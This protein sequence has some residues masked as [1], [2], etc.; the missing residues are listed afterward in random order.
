MNW[1]DGILL[2]NKENKKI[3][4]QKEWEIWRSVYPDMDKD[5]YIS[6]EDFRIKNSEV[7]QQINKPILTQ[8]EILAKADEI[9]RLH[10]GTHEGVKG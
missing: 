3:N 8:N 4:E 7:S 2:I 1:T 10:Q 6:Y 5:T 9:K